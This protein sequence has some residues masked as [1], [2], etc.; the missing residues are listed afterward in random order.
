M[1]LSGVS[2]RARDDVGSILRIG[3]VVE[4]DDRDFAELKGPRCEKS[5]V[6]CQDTGFGI[7]QNGILETE[8]G[9]CSRQSA[10]PALPSAFADFLRTG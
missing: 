6:A 2:G 8:L 1:S 3:K 5:A 7:H 9:R 10:R 4:N